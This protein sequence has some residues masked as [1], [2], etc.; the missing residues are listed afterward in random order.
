MIGLLSLLL[1]ACA[2]DVTT[3][4]DQSICLNIGGEAPDNAGNGNVGFV[5][6]VIDEVD[7]REVQDDY[8]SRYV[9]RV[10]VFD[11]FRNGFAANI[12]SEAALEEIRCEDSRIS[13]I[14]YAEIP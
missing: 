4:G 11:V 2:Q 10:A 7:A 8:T 1:C 6:I 3:N 12:N 9:D 13:S 14:E 5:V